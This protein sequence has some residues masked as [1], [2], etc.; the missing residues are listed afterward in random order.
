MSETHHS[1]KKA[2]FL[3]R[4]NIKN[5]WSGTYLYATIWIQTIFRY[6]MMFSQ[7][8]QIKPNSE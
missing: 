2:G 4:A 6:L 5:L 7:F 1:G 8:T 3:P